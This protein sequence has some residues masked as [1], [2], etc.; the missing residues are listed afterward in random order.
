L[1]ADDELE[2]DE[3]LTEAEL[4]D[5]DAL[6]DDSLDEDGLD[7]DVLDDSVELDD[8]LVV[9]EEDDDSD[10]D[11]DDSTATGDDEEEGE[12]SLDEIL[13][14]RSVAKRGSDEAEDEDEDIMALVPEPEVTTLDD[15]LPVEIT[16]VRD[17]EEFVCSN[18]HLVKKKVQL[19]DAKRMLCRDC[20]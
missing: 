14:E 15:V 10:D 7:D 1:F 4:D 20:A 8:E 13:A 12:A 9:T 2:D 18:C 3:E 17:Q 16:P 11:D 5:D 6:D 19:V